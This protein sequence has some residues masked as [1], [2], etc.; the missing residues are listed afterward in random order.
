MRG[1]VSLVDGEGA[2][3]PSKFMDYVSKCPEKWCKN[4]KSNNMNLP[5]YAYG[6]ISELSVVV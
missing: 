5:V 1:I 6:A 3:K 4:V 2:T